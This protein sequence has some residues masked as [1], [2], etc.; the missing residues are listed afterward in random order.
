[1][2]VKNNGDCVLWNKA[3]NSSGYGVLWKNN[4]Q[5]YAHRNA[6]NAKEGDVVMHT[7]DNRA[8]INPK[9]LQI[10]THSD[11]S[12]DMVLK[13]RQAKGENCGNSKLTK[14]EVFQIKSYLGVL[15]S[16]KVANIFN[17]SKT[18]VLDIWKNKI[19]KHL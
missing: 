10:G 19:W 16:R 7:C 14:E 18:N 3:I 4:K 15:S 6:V 11:N 5:V 1:M 13:N 12:K 9:H 17:I 2:Q 8:C